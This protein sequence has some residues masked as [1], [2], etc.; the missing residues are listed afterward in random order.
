MN[1]IKYTAL[2]SVIIVMTSCEKELDFEYHDID[3]LTVVE[4][5]LSQHGSVVTLTYT[6]PMNEPI[7]MTPITDATVT[8]TDFSTGDQYHLV[9]DANGSFRNMTPGI[10]GHRYGLTI[11]ENGRTYTAESTMLP[12][13]Q[14][15]DAVFKWIKMPGDDMAALQI[16]FTDN[17][18]TLDYYWVRIYRNDE[19]YMWSIISDRAAVDGILEETVTTTHRDTEQENDKSLLLDGDVVKISVTPVDHAMF[20][21]LTAL[22]A[23]NNGFKMINGESC[24]GF[25]I[26][27]PIATTSII[28]HPNQIEYAR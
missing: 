2:F 1:F 4:A 10:T 23:G 27:S 5:M 15:T 8:L 28:Y 12:P 7:D 26:A 24:L 11:T 18:S 22:A 20:D 25:F 16:R 19:P 21:N 14:I 9:A 6:T 13:T 3:A 17:P